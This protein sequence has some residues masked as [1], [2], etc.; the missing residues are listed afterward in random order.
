MM[1]PGKERKVGGTAAAKNQ[2]AAPADGEGDEFFQKLKRPH[3]GFTLI[4]V[5]DAFGSNFEGFRL[6]VAAVKMPEE[7]GGVALHRRRRRQQEMRDAQLRREE[8]MKLIQ[9]YLDYV[10]REK[11][12]KKE[13]TGWR[14]FEVSRSPEDSTEEAL[15]NDRE[16]EFQ[17]RAQQ[18]LARRQRQRR[19]HQVAAEVL[20][21]KRELSDCF[22][23]A[24][25]PSR[26]RTVHWYNKHGQLAEQIRLNAAVAWVH[27]HL[28]EIKPSQVLQ[29]T[30]HVLCLMRSCEYWPL[31]VDQTVVLTGAFRMVAVAFCLLQ[32]ALVSATR[33]WLAPF[34]RL[35]VS[36]PMVVHVVTD[37]A[38][39][40][41]VLEV[42]AD[43]M[44]LGWTVQSQVQAM[45]FGSTL[46]LGM[47]DRAVRQHFAWPKG[48]QI[49][50]LTVPKP[51]KAVAAT[52]GADVWVDNVTGAVVA[53]GKS[54]LTVARMEA[55]PN[56]SHFILADDAN[57][58][59]SSGVIGDAIVQ[60]W[61]GGKVDLEGSDINGTVSIKVDPNSS[62]QLLP[63]QPTKPAKANVTANASTGVRNATGHPPDSN[64][65]R[66]PSVN[67]TKQPDYATMVIP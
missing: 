50:T 19:M 2:G 55:N 25:L 24:D 1:L 36:S 47:D 20:K 31:S 52:G 34:E 4:C 54:N 61:N 53:D 67:A 66:G 26:S 49:A 41:P 12:A 7:A 14:L 62:V 17:R 63:A 59:I 8:E 22:K 35:Q 27:E 38:R 16:K 33:D 56:I 42:A 32:L 46:L 45:T 37:S 21:G 43:S 57:I 30:R 11:A 15:S 9:E 28:S 29:K 51:L 58:T 10:K 65:T 44:G 3:R 13:V 48:G 64:I 23:D 40:K 18:H 60:A 6:R 5:I 39:L